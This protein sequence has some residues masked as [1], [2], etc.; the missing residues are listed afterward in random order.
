MN[1]IYMYLDGGSTTSAS[2]T[3]YFDELRIGDKVEI[4]SDRLELAQAIQDANALRN[5]SVEGAEEGQFAIG[6]K[7]ILLSAIDAAP[8][9][10]GTNPELDPLEIDAI[11]ALAL[12]QFNFSQFPAINCRIG[13]AHIENIRSDIRVPPAD[14]VGGVILVTEQQI[15]F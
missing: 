1:R 3:V 6:S 11:Q 9:I 10:S 15:I 7:A 8:F 13:T 4:E 5:H 2:G 14:A 12:T